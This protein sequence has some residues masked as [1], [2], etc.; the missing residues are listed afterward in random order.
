MVFSPAFG[1]R[2]L[3]SKDEQCAVETE[4]AGCGTA[5]Y[6]LL[7]IATEVALCSIVHSLFDL[8]AKVN[9]VFVGVSLAF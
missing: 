2:G 5:C 1:C 4:H 9:A 3:A 7:S 6:Y 8:E